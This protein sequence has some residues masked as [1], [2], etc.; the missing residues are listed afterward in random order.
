MAD[1]YR[2]EGGSAP[3]IVSAPHVG[4]EVPPEMAARLSPKARGLPD[5]DWHVDRLYGQA[6]AMGATT[7]FANLSR[8]VVDL[9][10]DPSGRPLYPG[11]D[12]TEICPTRTFDD[13]P[14][15]LGAPPDAAEIA[16]RIERFWRPYH[17]RLRAALDETRARHGIVVLIDAHSIR[18]V[19]PRF[20]EGRLPDLNFGSADGASCAPELADRLYA[21]LDDPAFSRVRDGRF[22]GGFITRAY[23]RPARGVHA[24][25]LELAQS[26]YMDERPPWAWAPERA[27]GVEAV[28]GR[29]LAE[30]LDWA[31]GRD[32]CT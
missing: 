7:L 20:F 9:N 19:L 5:T 21:A 13:E 28:V 15:Y 14:I 24:A 31:A 23:G 18:S 22:K 4:T 30:A 10:R 12:N 29:M 8:Y 2:Y 27:A 32:R 3:L 11:A 26:A 17:D 6:R 25:Q 16:D 1:F